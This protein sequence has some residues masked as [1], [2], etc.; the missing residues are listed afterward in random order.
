MVSPCAPA[1]VSLER[2]ESEPDLVATE[3]G[4]L[5]T[6]KLVIP[7]VAPDSDVAESAS[8]LAAVVERARALGLTP[9]FHNH[10][11]EFDAAPSGPTLWEALEAIDGLAFELDLGWAWSA[12]QDPAGLLRANAG[13]CPLVHLKDMRRDGDKVTDTPLGDGE[14]DWAALVPLALESGVEW[15]IVEQDHPGD[16]PVGAVRQSY[17]YLER[18][19]ARFTRVRAR[20]QAVHTR[21]ARN[22]PPAWG[23]ESS[24]S[25]RSAEVM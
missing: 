4:T 23:S 5:G 16:D 22:S 3:L 7:W 21:P 15:L 12:H 2:F 6:G 1:H 25:P 19:L 18:L 13:R 9:I 10:W 17:D 11:F 24:D 8:R 14:I 20:R